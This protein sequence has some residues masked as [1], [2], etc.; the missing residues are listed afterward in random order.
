MFNSFFTFFSFFTAASCNYWTLTHLWG[1]C[2]C[3]CW[4][5]CWRWRTWSLNGWLV[6]DTGG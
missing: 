3:W 2:W 5:W 1:W 6:W 4:C